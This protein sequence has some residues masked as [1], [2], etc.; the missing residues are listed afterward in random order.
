[1][2][3]SKS[4]KAIFY[5]ISWKWSKNKTPTYCFCIYSDTSHAIP[6]CQKII[7]NNSLLKKRVDQVGGIPPE[8]AAAHL[9]TMFLWT[10]SVTSGATD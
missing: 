6:D 3:D 7:S 1:M 10:Y 5:Y 2:F 4:T 8:F 9:L